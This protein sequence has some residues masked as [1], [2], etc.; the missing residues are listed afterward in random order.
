MKVSDL[1]KLLS[2]PHRIRIIR[3]EDKKQL[4]IGYLSIFTMHT[5]K[6]P[7]TADF[8]KTI[9]DADVKKLRAIPEIRHKEWEE[10]G[11]MPPLEPDETPDYSFSDLRME[12]YYTIY[13]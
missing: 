4:W 2:E 7:A 12:L 6:D 1:F 5:A 3:E 10:K 8:V 9:M 13:I 11:L